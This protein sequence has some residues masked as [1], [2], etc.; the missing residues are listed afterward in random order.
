[1]PRQKGASVPLSKKPRKP[2]KP[3]GSY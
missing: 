1:V 3:K 2:K